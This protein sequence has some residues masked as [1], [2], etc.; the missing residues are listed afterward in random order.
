M[1]TLPEPAAFFWDQGNERKNLE[2]HG[3]TAQEVEEVFFDPQKKLLEDKFHSGKEDRYILIGQ[4]KRRR[5]L[6]VVFTIRNR[7]IRTIS[8][9][10]LNRKERP[11]YEEET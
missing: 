5:L 6:F 7:Q 9:R 2:K 11:L 8:A 3:V 4:T 10:D 1:I